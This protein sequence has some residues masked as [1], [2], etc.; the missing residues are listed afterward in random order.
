MYAH[1]LELT[2]AEVD[3]QEPRRDGPEPD[4]RLDGGCPSAPEEIVLDLHPGQQEGRFRPRAPPRRRSISCGSWGSF[5]IFGLQFSSSRTGTPG[6]GVQG[7]R[8]PDYEPDSNNRTPSVAATSTG[9]RQLNYCDGLQGD[10]GSVVF[11]G[12][13]QAALKLTEDRRPLTVRHVWISCR[14][15]IP[16]A[17]SSLPS[18]ETYSS[19]LLRSV[20]SN[21][22]RPPV[23]FGLRLRRP[24]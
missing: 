21:K 16:T 9:I 15:P 6:A 2:A 20:P 13:V 1:R 10:K 8:A 18:F 19:A 7:F 4:R 23:G 12:S 5:L 24:V 17:R 14:K 3:E 22:A 11:V